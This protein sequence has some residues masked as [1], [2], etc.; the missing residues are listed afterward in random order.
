[1]R[2]R[3][4][5]VVHYVSRDG[6]ALDAENTLELFAAYRSLAGDGPHLILS[7]IR[8]VRSSTSE[9]R[10][11]ATTEDATALHRAAGVI[12]GSRLTRMMG[13]LFLRLNRPGYPTRLFSDEASALAWLHAIEQAELPRAG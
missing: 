7:D 4:D 1:M 8:G 10:A 6:A 11:L 12:V 3:E 9:S 5:G 13:N 2:L